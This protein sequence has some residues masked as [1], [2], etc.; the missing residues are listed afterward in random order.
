[1]SFRSMLHV[2]AVGDTVYLTPAER[3]FAQ[4]CLEERARDWCPCHPPRNADT[5]RLQVE[6]NLSELAVQRL[7]G[8]PQRLSWGMGVRH[9]HVGRFLGQRCSHRMTGDL[10]ADIEVPAWL[11]QPARKIAVQWNRGKPCVYVRRTDG[12]MHADMIVA[13]EVRGGFAVRVVQTGKHDGRA[14]GEYYTLWGES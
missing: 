3:R 2:P 10:L 1:M 5:A 11:G 8:V 12:T 7:A 4:E 13:T 14:F 6:T 9:T